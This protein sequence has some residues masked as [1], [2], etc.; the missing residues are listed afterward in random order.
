MESRFPCYCLGLERIL[1]PLSTA[2][3]YPLWVNA[4]IFLAAAVFV[5]TSGTRLTRYLDA[6]AVKTGLGQAFVGM[7]LLGGITSL[8]EI[9][10]SIT[11]SWIGNPAL[12]VNNLLGSASINLL[13]LAI[14]DAFIGRDALTSV[15]AQPSTLMQ[16]ALCMLVLTL[17]G[18]AITSGDVLIFGVG[19]W[20]LV[21]CAVSI[22]AFW[23]S[24]TYD[25]VAPW[26]LKDAARVDR[27]SQDQSPEDALSKSSVGLLTLKTA[28]AGSVIFVAGYALAQTGDALAV[29]TGLGTGLVG[30]VLIGMATSLP[31]LS[32]ITAAIRMHRYEMAI[33]EILGTNF[34]NVSLI[35]LNDSVYTGGPVINELGAFETISALLG[36]TLT[37]IF[38]VGLLERRDSTVMRMGYDSLAVILLFTGGVGLLYVIGSG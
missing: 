3:E 37:G 16:A 18:V 13:L 15:V 5:W 29:Q 6:I 36:A 4:L 19:A 1:V 23:L 31:E 10:N 9:A 21:L 30:F 34:V 33:G 2:H 20:G 26:T 17:V 11:S 25:R 27:E 32:S 38:L 28:L 22:A 12:A 7:L 14:V 35:L 24:A 8:P